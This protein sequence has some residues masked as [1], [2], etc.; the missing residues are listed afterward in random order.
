MVAVT[1]VAAPWVAGCDDATGMEAEGALLRACYLGDVR[2]ADR[3]LSAGCDVIHGAMLGAME[4]G[5]R[6]D[7]MHSNLGPLCL[8]PTVPLQR[9]KL[10]TNR[11]ITTVGTN[12]YR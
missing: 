12:S 10:R 1:A 2:A 5:R 9:Q 3:L 8:P 4:D 11:K 7:G 6:S